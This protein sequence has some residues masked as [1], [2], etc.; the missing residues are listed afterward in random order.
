MSHFTIG[1]SKNCI[2]LRKEH[3]KKYRISI[4]YPIMEAAQKHTK[5]AKRQLNP[6]SINASPSDRGE[7]RAHCDLDS[8][9]R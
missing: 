4:F 6:K 5:I 2:M 9:D 1:G 3:N 7:Y 8:E